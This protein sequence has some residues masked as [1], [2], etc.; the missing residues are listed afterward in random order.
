MKC[1]IGVKG[2]FFLN[3]DR[4]LV[5]RRREKQIRYERSILRELS[6]KVLKKSVQQFFG[7]FHTGKGLMLDN[8]VEEGC[9][10]IA[11]ESYLLGGQY[12]RVGYYGRNVDEIKER[13]KEQ[14]ENLAQALSEFIHYWTHLGAED[15]RD[16]SLLSR[17]EE[18]VDYWWLEG[19]EKGKMKYKMKLH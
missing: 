18:F 6:I 14:R 4:S 9:F 16:E 12:S 3:I 2:V 7:S 1:T 19:F 5:K 17:C 15:V 13:T 8:A 11:V 10:D